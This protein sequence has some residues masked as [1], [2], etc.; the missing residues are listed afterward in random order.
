MVAGCVIMFTF[1]ILWF[2]IGI[3]GGRFS[4][5]VVRAGIVIV[6]IVLLAWVLMLRRKINRLAQNALSLTA[7]QEELDRQLGRRFGWING[8]QGGAI[9]ASIVVLNIVRRPDFIAPVIA[10]IV[11]LHFLPL[12][13][14]FQRP[15]YYATGILGTTIGIAGFFI[16]DP[17]T[18]QSLVGLSFGLLLWLTVTVMLWNV[19]RAVRMMQE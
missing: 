12:V 4:P 18:R 15:L 11:G 16:A 17:S 14:L 19:S 10:V 6:G 7:E 2:L 8:I 1:S 5:M 13:G 3:A 9:I